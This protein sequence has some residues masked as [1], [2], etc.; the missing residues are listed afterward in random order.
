[1]WSAT[2]VAAFV[3]DIP[4]DLA[5]YHNKNAKKKCVQT[6]AEHTGST[7]SHDNLE[8]KGVTRE[9][10][11]ARNQ[12]RPTW[13]A[14]HLESYTWME[15]GRL[16]VTVQGGEQ[17]ILNAT[18]QYTKTTGLETVEETARR[19][20]HRLLIGSV[21]CLKIFEIL[22]SIRPMPPDFEFSDLKKTKQKNSKVKIYDGFIMSTELD[23]LEIRLN[24]LDSVVDY[25]IIVEAR[26]THTNK[27]KPL[28]FAENSTRF[29]RFASKIRSVVLNS[30]PP[31]ASPLECEIM[32]RNAIYGGVHPDADGMSWVM[33]S[34]IDEIPRKEKVAFLRAEIQ[35]KRQR[36]IYF[37]AAFHYYSF[38]WKRG[39]VWHAPAALHVND[40]REGLSLHNARV[41]YAKGLPSVINSGSW[42]MSFFG[43][44]D[45]IISKMQTYSHQEYNT[46][47][48][49]ARDYVEVKL[50]PRLLPHQSTY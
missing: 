45:A 31:G 24:E 15:D 33:V 1:M 28:H 50:I 21:P 9:K 39:D 13:V 42:H 10:Q 20:C 44:P 26:A 32:Q 25:F 22:K 4:E 38:R 3:T 30:F 8:T 29:K 37:R 14:E 47:K 23:L 7:T 2:H 35:G 40:I 6:L 43:G 34:D 19:E 17:R 12:D 18:A 11:A 41:P 49:T 16:A 46:E 48:L 27:P 5:D 36:P